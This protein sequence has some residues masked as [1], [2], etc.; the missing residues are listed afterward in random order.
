MPSL[1]L[2]VLSPTLQAR[3]EVNGLLHTHT[4]RQTH[5][6]TKAIEKSGYPP[7]LSSCN[8]F[9]IVFFNIFGKTG[10][11][12]DE[13]LL[14]ISNKYAISVLFDRCFLTNSNSQMISASY[15]MRSGKK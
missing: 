13:L 15:D 14:F 8:L 9:C 12:F 2:N 1:A 7:S 6:L 4:Y 11:P 3:V 5:A 10:S